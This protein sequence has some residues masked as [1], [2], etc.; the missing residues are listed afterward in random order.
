MWVIKFL[1]KYKSLYSTIVTKYLKFCIHV[2]DNSPDQNV[3]EVILSLVNI[4]ILFQKF[5][6][7]EIPD[8]E[9]KRNQLHCEN[10]LKTPNK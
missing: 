2:A 3:N 9:R 8:I 4:S 7:P 5:L 10:I 6:F 1:I